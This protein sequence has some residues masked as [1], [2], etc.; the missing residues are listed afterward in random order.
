[1]ELVF[2]RAEFL[3]APRASANVI[4]TYDTCP[5]KVR[6]TL[7]VRNGQ[8]FALCSRAR[9]GGAPLSAHYY[10]VFLIFFREFPRGVHAH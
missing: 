10:S 4:K 2:A 1:M 8:I 6:R 7:A 5:G 9:D 3:Q